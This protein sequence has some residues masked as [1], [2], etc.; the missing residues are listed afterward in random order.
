MAIN[1]LQLLFSVDNNHPSTL[2]GVEIPPGVREL[3]IYSPRIPDYPQSA[4]GSIFEPG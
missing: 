2:L 4:T 3:F 1:G